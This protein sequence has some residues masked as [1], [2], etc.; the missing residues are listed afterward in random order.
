MNDHRWHESTHPTAKDLWLTSSPPA[1][2]YVV[3]H[4]DPSLLIT[5]LFFFAQPRWRRWWKRSDARSIPRKMQDL[6]LPQPSF[7]YSLWEVW[8]INVHISTLLITVCSSGNIT[9]IWCFELLESNFD[10]TATPLCSICF[11]K[12]SF[13]VF[14]LFQW[15]LS[16]ICG[17]LCEETTQWRIRWESRSEPKFE[18]KAV[19]LK[20]RRN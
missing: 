9:F 3:S 5:S 6:K 17:N 20:K 16:S 19:S 2:E 8:G 14:F 13:V 4:P 1:G 11:N 18:I 7:K 10:I 12:G 15:Q